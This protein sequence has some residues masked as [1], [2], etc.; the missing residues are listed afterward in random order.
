MRRT[1]LLIFLTPRVVKNNT[2]SEVLKQIEAER[3]HY[4][5]CEAEALHGPLFGIPEAQADGSAPPVYA[6]GDLW[7]TK[8]G[9]PPPPPPAPDEKKPPRVLPVPPMNETP[10]DV[11]GASFQQSAGRNRTPAVPMPRPSSSKSNQTPR[12][13]TILDT[14]R[15]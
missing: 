12:K 11:Q 6:P 14:F 2:A 13:K 9:I 5:E 3:L 1:E 8:K 10:D 15:K 7:N 4:T